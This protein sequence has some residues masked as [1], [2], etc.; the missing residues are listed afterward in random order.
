MGER[1]DAAA[2]A[3]GY[4]VVVWRAGWGDWR[5]TVLGPDTG[6]PVVIAGVWGVGPLEYRA[7]C[8]WVA[9]IDAQ[10]WVARQ[11]R[12]ER[13]NAARRVAIAAERGRE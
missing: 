6:A 10:R 13:V 5:S 1:D 4:R 3:S 8:R 7:C 11:L 9:K 12:R 2:R